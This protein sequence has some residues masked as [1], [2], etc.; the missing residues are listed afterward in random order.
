MGGLNLQ[1]EALTVPFGTEFPGNVQALLVQIAQ[2]IEIVGD[3]NFTGVN[4]GPVE[5]DPDNR[6]KPWFK[7]D[8]SG[9]PIGWYSWNGAAWEPIPIV[10]PS[11][12]TGDRPSS[13]QAGTQFYDSTINVALIYNGSAWVT[14]A[15]S[16]GDVKEVTATS[17]AAAL[18]SNPGWLQDTDSIGYVVAGASDG[19]GAGAGETAGND[20]IALTTDQLPAH[21]HTD[22]VVT[23][24]SADN[25]DAGNLVITAASANIGAETILNSSTGSTGSGAS[26]DIRQHTLYRF[27]LVK[28]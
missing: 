25:G 22:L 9:N 6:D 23:G 8:G 27:K 1:L 21:N 11:G 20:S 18:T 16:P 2:Y 12:S 19:T 3:E 4:F 10:L 28:S 26:I 15:G 7:T 5:P 24:S 14:L 13:P 17:L